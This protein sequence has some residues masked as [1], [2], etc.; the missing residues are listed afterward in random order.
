[1]SIVYSGNDV[2]P[3]D[4]SSDHKRAEITILRQTKAYVEKRFEYYMSKI[5]FVLKQ[6]DDQ[7]FV[8]A[9]QFTN[10]KIEQN[11][12][13]KDYPELRMTFRFE[14]IFGGIHVVL[15]KMYIALN[16]NSKFE[17]ILD[18]GVADIET[19]NTVQRLLDVFDRKFLTQNS[20]Q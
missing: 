17:G 14:D 20:Y 16:Q 18:L 15:T 11:E 6:S 9:N 10:Y 5:G 12:P 1:M 7:G 2:E 4:V 19:I 8:F 3:D 13:N